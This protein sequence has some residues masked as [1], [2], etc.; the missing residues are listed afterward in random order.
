MLF[1]LTLLTAALT[2]LADLAAVVEADTMPET[3][4]FCV[5]GT[6]SYVLVFQ[7]KLC[8]VLIEN[9]G[10]GVDVIGSFRNSPTPVSSTLR[11]YHFAFTSGNDAWLLL[12]TG[13]L[14]SVALYNVVWYNS[15][16]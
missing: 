3:R 10:I 2:R 16:P 1:A 4:D 5:T 9:E 8:H 11:K 14:Y 12:L 7:Y 15:A 13:T 6:V